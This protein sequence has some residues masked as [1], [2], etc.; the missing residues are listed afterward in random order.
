MRN[1]CWAISFLVFSSL[2]LS[3]SF[4]VGCWTGSEVALWYGWCSCPISSSPAW[5]CVLTRQSAPDGFSLGKANATKYNRN[6]T[7][8]CQTQI[9][10]QFPHHGLVFC[11]DKPARPL[12]VEFCPGA[13][14]ATLT[15]K[16]S[17]QPI[18]IL[19]Q[20]IWTSFSLEKLLDISLMLTHRRSWN[21][22][23]WKVS[24]FDISPYLRPPSSE[25]TP[26]W[27]KSYETNKPIMGKVNTSSSLDIQSVIIVS[28]VVSFK[29]CSIN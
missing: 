5:V 1:A 19:H 9:L 27:T 22:A 14:Q 23:A 11:F 3:Q 20:Q 7:K 8:Q 21:F 15:S 29:A 28:C 16:R 25:P 6:I 17:R 2:W 26:N 10:L 13:R 12:A 4:F 18:P 24:G